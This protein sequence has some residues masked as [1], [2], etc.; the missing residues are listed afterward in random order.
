MDDLNLTNK[1][2]ETCLKLNYT[3]TQ[4]YVE[5]NDDLGH[6][7]SFW[8]TMEI[9]Q[10]SEN[11]RGSFFPSWNAVQPVL[12]DIYVNLLHKCGVKD[13]PCCKTQPLMS[14]YATTS[15]YFHNILNN[16]PVS[17]VEDYLRKELNL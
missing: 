5:K 2:S 3:W 12:E 17:S 4:R 8:K 7:R 6:I 1:L 9:C 13:K 15:R 16:V 11:Y 10:E 14:I